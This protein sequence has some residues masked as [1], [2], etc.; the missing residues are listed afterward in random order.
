MRW[1]IVPHRGHAACLVTVLA[2]IRTDLPD[3]Y[4]LSICRPARWGKRTASNSEI[5]TQHDQQG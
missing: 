2:R 5:V 1:E 4:T 3:R